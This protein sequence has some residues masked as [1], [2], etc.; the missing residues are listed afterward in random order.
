MVHAFE[1][2]GQ[3]LPQVTKRLKFLEQIATGLLVNQDPHGFLNVLRV[4]RIGHFDDLEQPGS[5]AKVALR[6]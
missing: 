6:G 3:V 5:V 1:S 4:L 2:S